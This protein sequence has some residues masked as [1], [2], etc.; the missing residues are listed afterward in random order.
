M[1]RRGRRF[2]TQ[3]IVSLAA[4]IGGVASLGQFHWS[5][6]VA[7]LLA[8]LAA[9]FLWPVG[10]PPEGALLYDRGPAVIGPDLLGIVLVSG[11]AGLPFFAGHLSG[12]FL[13]FSAFI[14]WP[15]AALFL[16]LPIIGWRRGC[17]AILIAPEGISMDTGWRQIAL[18]FD[19]IASIG[20]WRRD[21]VR[22]V[23]P[24]APLLI[25]AGKF[26][27]AGALMVSRES[28]GVALTLASGKKFAI[29][30]D[31]FETGIRR[32]LETARQHGI[33]V[34]PGTWSG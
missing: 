16:S 30:G 12:V 1:T 5:V 11:F 13:H 32:L 4:G 2:A 27:T 10:A 14:L 25:A 19:D 15:M 9:Y 31:G 6:S 29:P 8:G 7:I 22:F 3:R 21:L 26:G 23:R 17:F 33:P 24:L 34:A 18:E 20:P 28:H